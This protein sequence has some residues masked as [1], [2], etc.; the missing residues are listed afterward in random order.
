MQKNFRELLGT[1]IREKLSKGLIGKVCDFVVN[2]ANGEILAFFARK[3][4]KLLLPTVDISQVSAETVW[5]E[6]PE[7]LATPDE[8]VRI[9]EVIKLNTPIFTNKVFTVSRNYLG[10]VIDFRFEMNGWILT[11]IE[12]AK[13]ILG[14]PTQAK[15]IN[16]SQ[17]VRI[18]SNEI[19]VRDVVVKVTAKKIRETEK[20]ALNLTPAALKVDSE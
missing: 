3:D 13:K 8:I 4:K 10:E 5:V 20:T 14:I 1:P 2:P 16:S 15:L 19:T 7:A 9:A 11:K 12:V 6:D 18:K 17:I